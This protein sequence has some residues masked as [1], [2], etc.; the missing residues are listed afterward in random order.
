M[1]P[2][3]SD[4]NTAGQDTFKTFPASSNCIAEMVMPIYATKNKTK[5]KTNEINYWS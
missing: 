5:N 1:D 2:A 3:K 4:P